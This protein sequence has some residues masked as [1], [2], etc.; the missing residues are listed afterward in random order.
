MP[1]DQAAAALREATAVVTTRWRYGNA[2]LREARNLRAIIDVSG[3]WPRVDYR[4]CFS[5]AIHVLSCAPSFGPGVAEM[6][7]GMAIAACREIVIGDA[8]FRARRE[9]WLRA[10]NQST[11]MLRG[12]PIGLIGFGGLAR[13]LLPLLGPFQCAVSVY[14]PSVSPSE[15]RRKGCQPVD[16]DSLLR[17]S[18]VIFVLLGPKP[19]YKELL[20]RQRLSLIRS[21]A[22]LVLAGRSYVIDF[23]AL[24][25]FVLEG[26]FKAAID[27]F[28]E[29]PLPGDHP[30]RGAKHAILS[31]HRAGSVSETLQ[32]IGRDVVDDLEA[33]LMGASPHRLLE[34]RLERMAAVDLDPSW[35]D[36]P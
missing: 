33:V 16:L 7:L 8:D 3:S 26:R 34:A 22:V 19:Q 1:P 21:D 4:Y 36:V 30:I 27:V 5:R 29:E 6:M 13:S 12:K 17:T 20:N 11:F 15:I 25:E 2:M 35:P 23:D 32:D 9:K 10:G 31:A 18:R 14:H 28:P 24:T